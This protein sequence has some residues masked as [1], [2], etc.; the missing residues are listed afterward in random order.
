MQR[1]DEM[2]YNK[3]HSLTHTHI[4]FTV[5]GHMAEIRSTSLPEYEAVLLIRLGANNGAS[6]AIQVNVVFDLP[7][8]T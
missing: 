5:G 1:V 6:P 3:K 7:L 2:L 4:K 8:L